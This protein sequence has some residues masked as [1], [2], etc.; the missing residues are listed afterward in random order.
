VASEVA[1][2]TASE[3]TAP[4]SITAAGAAAFVEEPATI[5]E[6][7][8]IEDAEE[9]SEAAPS[10]PSVVVDESAD[11]IAQVCGIVSERG[12]WADLK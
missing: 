3:D 12:C 2:E 10:I 7:S 5:G 9:T 6:V 4:P 8:A 11:Q 1:P